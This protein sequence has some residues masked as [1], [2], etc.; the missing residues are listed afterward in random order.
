M[1]IARLT[2]IAGAALLM[3]FPQPSEGQRCPDVTKLTR[4][5][6]QLIAP[7]RYLADDALE[8]RLAGS[9]AERCAGD[10]IASQFKAIGLEA[11]GAA[12]SYFMEVPL[13][14]VLNPHAASGTGRNVVGVLRGRSPTLRDEWVIV[15]AHYDHLG[16]GARGSAAPDQPNAIHNGA[17]DNAS[18]VAAL[19][20]IARG[21]TQQR[22]ERSVLFIAFTG[23]EAGLLGSSAFTAHPSI[24]LEHTRAML[25]L[26]MVGR[27]GTGPLI[28]YGTGTAKEWDAIVSAATAAESVAFKAQPEGYGPSDH[29]SFYMRDVPVLH[30]FTNVH[31][32]Y[33]KPS[34]DWEKIDAAGLNKVARVVSRIAREAASE[35]PVTLVRGAGNP[36]ATGVVTRGSSYL[37]TVP[38]FT[39]VD[40]GVLLS[41][42]TPGSPGEK[43]GLKKGDII[44]KFDD[45]VIADLQGM[46]DA[47]SAR[48]PGDTVKITVL[49]EGKEVVLA[50]VL[51]TRNR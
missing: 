9:P 1:T 26:D 10:F 5:V 35:R 19:L 29:T 27:L 47:L 15:G 48:K 38:D 13:A 16:L 42:V 2:R 21:L 46:T 40:R 7:I 37:G 28:I 11:G 14:S 18:G 22:P 20:A 41:G 6:P 33:H 4:G 32:D 8:G 39:P 51:G 43:A 49:R 25:N 44:L 23:E 36:P 34:D 3:L 45:D 50:A 12:G 31:G 17:D 30:F 24:P